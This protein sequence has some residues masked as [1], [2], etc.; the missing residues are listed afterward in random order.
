[1]GDERCQY[2]TESLDSSSHAN[3]RLEKS[4]Q[5]QRTTFGRKMTAM[6]NLMTKELSTFVR[7]LNQYSTVQRTPVTEEIE[8]WFTPSLSRIIMQTAQMSWSTKLR[9]I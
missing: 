2:L 3:S 5:K 8:R 7:L 1:M 6:I 4:I 9:Y